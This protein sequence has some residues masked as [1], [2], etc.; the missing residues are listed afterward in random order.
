MAKI[1]PIICCIFLAAGAG[2]RLYAGDRDVELRAILKSAFRANERIRNLSCFSRE[3][4]PMDDPDFPWSKDNATA[5]V[6]RKS[7][8]GL[9]LLGEFQITVDRVG[10][11]LRYDGC[12]FPEKAREARSY[13]NFT[14]A[15]DGSLY[16]IYKPST[17]TGS[18]LQ[19]QGQLDCWRSMHSLLG[20]GIGGYG[21]MVGADLTFWLNKPEGWSFES[22]PGAVRPRIKRYYKSGG[23]QS[24]MRMH[25][26]LAPEHDYLPCLIETFWCDTRTEC[27]QYKIE[28]FQSFSI[29][30]ASALTAISAALARSA[31]ICASTAAWR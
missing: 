27:Y 7:P 24:G 18:Q 5:P 6:L 3:Y 17:N 16:R 19:Y 9:G 29:L 23:H 12:E 2:G 8:E 11:R 26:T 25:I 14:A 28:H 15:F 10:H 4:E 20:D 13:A 21:E 30:S 22:E 1:R 31:C